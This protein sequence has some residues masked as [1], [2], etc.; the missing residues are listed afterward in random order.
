MVGFLVAVV[1]GGAERCDEEVEQTA[2][3]DRERN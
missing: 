3:V 1:E 2:A